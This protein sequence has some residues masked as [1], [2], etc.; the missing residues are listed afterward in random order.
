MTLEY[1]F[2]LLSDKLVAMGAICS[3]AELQGMLCGQ[4][5]CGKQQGDDAWISQA[6]DFS[7]LSHFEITVGQKTLILFLVEATQNSLKDEDMAFQPLLPDD[8]CPLADRAKELGAWCRGFLHGFGI[9]G[10]AQNKELPADIVEVVRDLA[11]ISEAVKA[12]E[13]EENDTE[14]DWYEL[15]E[16]LRAGVLTVYAELGADADDAGVA[17]NSPSVH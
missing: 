5:A 9:S 13:E 12:V 3:V 7:D 6:R 14:N 1:D 10:I 2:Q 16:Y 17:G 11:K 4:L 8:A 15:V